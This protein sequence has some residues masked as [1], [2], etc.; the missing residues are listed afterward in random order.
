MDMSPACSYP[1]QP[2][3]TEADRDH[4]RF[5]EYSHWLR[6]MRRQLVSGNTFKNWLAQT[7]EAERLARPHVSIFQFQGKHP[8]AGKWGRVEYGHKWRVLRSLG[9]FDSRAE[10][11]VSPPTDTLFQ[12][13]DSKYG[14]RAGALYNSAAEAEAFARTLED[15]L[16]C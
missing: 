9:P 13:W 12:V 1:V 16:A 11:E 15:S 7:E 2:T 5:A 10:S 4:P 8:H 6:A 14:R 3:A